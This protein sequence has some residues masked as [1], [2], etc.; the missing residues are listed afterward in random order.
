VKRLLAPRVLLWSGM[1]VFAAAFTTLSLLRYRAFNDGR[2]D[3][4]NI[5][6]AVWTTAHGHLLVQTDLHGRQI[7]RLGVHFEPVLFVFAGLWRIWPS[8]DLLLTAQPVVLALGALPVYWLAHKHLRSER[9]ALWLAFAYLL[10]PPL[11]W[12]ALDEFHPGA[13]ACPL[14]LFAF[15]YLDEDRLLP[16][17]LFA[18]AACMT[19][20]EIPLVVAGMGAWYALSRRRRSVGGAIFV[21]GLA[22]TALIVGVVEPH[23]RHGAPLSFYGRYKEIGGSP[24]H[25]LRTAVTHPLRVLETAFDR[26]GLRYLLELVLPLAG[27]CL[28]APLVLLAAVPLLAVNLLSG[29]PAQTSIHYHYLAGE[30]PVLVAAAVLG[31]AWAV[32][33]NRRLAL[34]LSVAAVVAALV[35]NYLLGPLPFWSRVPGGETLGAGRSSVS[36]HDDLAAAAIRRIPPG[37]VVSATNGLGSHLSARRRYLSFPLTAGAAWVAYDTKNPSYLDRL[38]S[39]RGRGKLTH[40]QASPRWR[41]V[42]RRDGILVFRRT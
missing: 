10:Y 38:R 23:F 36:H 29:D 20:E 3:L 25:V 11:Q 5:V 12:V 27:L 18:L 37:A 24:G 19:R 13:L 40:I 26:H 2:F 6:Q 21:A 31:A 14:L 4:G 22:A 15:W 8:P 7:S 41:L 9:A 33:R 32:R 35:A 34:P 28:L 16:F 39:T 42:F 1:A 17:A 30:I